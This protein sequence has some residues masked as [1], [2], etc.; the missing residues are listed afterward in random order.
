MK[1]LEEIIGHTCLSEGLLT[2]VIESQNASF[3]ADC[4]VGDG[5]VARAQQASASL[6]PHGSPLQYFSGKKVA[7]QKVAKQ[8]V[9]NIIRPTLFFSFVQS[10]IFLTVTVTTQASEVFSRSSTYLC[11]SR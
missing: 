7:N 4:G 8:N 10:N 9:S 1:G 2:S 5:A 6:M 11:Q 3:P